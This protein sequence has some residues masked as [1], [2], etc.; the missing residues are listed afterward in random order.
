MEVGVAMLD[1]GRDGDVC[2]TINLNHSTRLRPRLTE[3]SGSN[4]EWLHWAQILRRGL[5]M[6]D[7]PNARISV[8]PASGAQDLSL[9]Y[10]T[11]H[12]VRL[13]KM[14]AR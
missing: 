7:Q 1:D 12:L 5:R 14:D 6:T 9:L 2:P 11:P 3:R 4:G 13:L 8:I 10:F